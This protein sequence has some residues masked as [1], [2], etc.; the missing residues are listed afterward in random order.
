MTGDPE[1]LELLRSILDWHMVHGRN[2]TGIVWDGYLYP[3]PLNL[4]LPAYAYAYPATGDRQ[5]LEEGLAFLRFTGLPRPETGV[6]AGGKQYRTYVP[7]LLLAHES[8]VLDE[9]ERAAAGN[10]VG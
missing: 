10:P 2:P 5:Y 8:G 4:T 3:Y 9:M 6:R 1:A 7:F